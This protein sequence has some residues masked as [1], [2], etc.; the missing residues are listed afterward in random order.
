MS[1]NKPVVLH[2]RRKFLESSTSIDTS[3]R[4]LHTL[5]NKAYKAKYGLNLTDDDD[6]A[7]DSMETLMAVVA[8]GS[9]VVA[10]RLKDDG[11]LNDYGRLTKSTEQAF[12]DAME[13]V[14]DMLM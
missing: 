14:I 13:D 6:Y 10:S 4:R 12:L 9:R 8:A 3:V 1:N 5:A 2:V 11:H 7:N